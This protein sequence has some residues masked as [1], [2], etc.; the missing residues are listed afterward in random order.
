M[1][2]NT[3]VNNKILHQNIPP[4]VSQSRSTVSE[5]PVEP[6]SPAE[7]ETSATDL[8]APSLG[9][10][11]ITGILVLLTWFS[12]WRKNHYFEANYRFRQSIPCRNCRFM[13]QNF[14]LK[15]AVHPSKVMKKEA[16]GCPDYWAKDSNKFSQK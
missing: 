3:A 1:N 11:S 6:M 7:V 15:C 8:I 2:E 16:I 13:N 14:Y 9:I 10:V 5:V 12:R 4:V